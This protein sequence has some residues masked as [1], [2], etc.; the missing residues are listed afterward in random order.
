MKKKYLQY[1]LK[2]AKAW[3]ISEKTEKKIIAQFKFM[4]IS[5]L[6]FDSWKKSNQKK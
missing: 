5:H 6:D 4:H 1:L 3:H 2:R